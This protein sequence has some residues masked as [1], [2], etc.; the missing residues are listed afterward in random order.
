MLKKDFTYVNSLFC[1]RQDAINVMVFD[2]AERLV[3]SSK[4]VLDHSKLK[5]IR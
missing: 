2:A 5:F 4:T 1:V 3:M